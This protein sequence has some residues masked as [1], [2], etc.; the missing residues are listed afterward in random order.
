MAGPEAIDDDTRELIVRLLTRVGMIIE[1]ASATAVASAG[2]R[3]SLVNVIAR[4]EKASRAIATL[5]AAAKTLA[6]E[7][8]EEPVR[9]EQH[10]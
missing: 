3:A 9:G 7:N 6:N 5:V 4:V 10:P 8:F 1:D 2:Q